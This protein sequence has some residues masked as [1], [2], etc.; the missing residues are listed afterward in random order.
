MM[1]PAEVMEL[2]IKLGDL[3][4][5]VCKGCRSCEFAIIENKTVKCSL[6]HTMLGLVEYKNRLLKEKI[7]I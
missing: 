2:M 1:K 3:D 4:E 7:D 5:Y 6:Y